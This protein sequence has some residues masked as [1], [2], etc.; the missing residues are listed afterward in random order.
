MSVPEALTQ[1]DTYTAGQR[2]GRTAFQG[3]TAFAAVVV[4]AWLARVVG[5]DL[6]PGEGDSMPAEIGAALE[7]LLTAGVSWFMNRQAVPSLG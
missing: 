6:D 3:G 1:K 7:L 2:V 5:L 4:L